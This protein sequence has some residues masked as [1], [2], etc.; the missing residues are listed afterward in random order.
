[1][2]CINFLK[3]FNSGIKNIKIYLLGK[4]IGDTLYNYFAHNNTIYWLK[5]VLS[6]INS[7][8]TGSLN[9]LSAR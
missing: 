8:P 9:F 1:M 4:Q 2:A 3:I 7:G 5:T 6:F